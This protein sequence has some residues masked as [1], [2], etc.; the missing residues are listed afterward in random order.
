MT[1]IR[2]LEKKYAS[3]IAAIHADALSKDFLPSLGVSFLTEL[4]KGILELNLG[5]GFVAKDKNT[6]QGFVLATKDMQKMLKTVFFKR[7]FPL[8]RK[9]L[10]ALLK[11]PLK[12]LKIFE[13]FTYS[14][15][16]SK[17]KTKSELIVVAVDRLFRNQ[18]IGSNLLLTL[19]H[20]FVKQKV[21]EYKVT[22]NAD[23]LGAIKFYKGNGFK[24]AYR[25]SLYR[26]EW[27]LLIKKL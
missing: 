8:G 1:T 15:K 19:D 25:F 9:I 13:T 2:V 6:I 16:E 21:K 12:I 4:Y 23:N 14:G 26:K 5:F 20:E 22:V 11:N 7:T 27:N 18:K 24:F 10:P 3:D 17:T